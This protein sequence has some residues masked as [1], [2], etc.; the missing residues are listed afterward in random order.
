MKLKYLV[1]I[2]SMILLF[3]CNSI[4]NDTTSGSML[5]II[6]L[7]GEDGELPLF[8]GV[9]ENSNDLC[10][11]TLMAYPIDPSKEKNEITPYMDIIVDQVEVEY[12][13]TDGR[14]IEGVD[15]PYRFTEPM[16]FIVGING[17]SE[18]PVTVI[19]HVAKLEAPLLALREYPNQGI[20]LQ[21][22]AKLTFQGKDGGGHRVAPVSGYITVWC[23]SE[24][25]K[26]DDEGE[27]D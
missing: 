19:R 27:G 12:M 16:N 6:S 13:R 17:E 25:V 21:L 10:L 4:E 24:F 26:P 9:K 23:S 20:V 14:N 15:V 3:S 7:T 22:V 8:S 5:K 11:A 1:L 2:I 18:I